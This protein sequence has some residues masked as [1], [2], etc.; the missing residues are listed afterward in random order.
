VSAASSQLA[1]SAQQISSGAQ[2]QAASLEETAASL[3]EI[4][5]TVK[6]NAD[7]A[8]H[9]SNLAGG[10]RD[11]AERG[12]KVVDSAVHAM[13]E[14]T[15][16]SRK[17]ADIITTIDE[18]AFQTN[19]LALNAAVE[20]ARAGEQGRGFGVVAAEVR[21]LAQRT[22]TAAKEIRGLIADSGSKVEAGT[23]QVDHSGQTLAA[24]V[25]SVKQ[26]TDMITVIADASRE[27]MAGIEQVNN[28]VTQVDQVT[29][30]N[31]AQT[32]E[33]SATASSLSEKAE[34][35]RRRVSKFKLGGETSQPRGA[36]NVVALTTRKVA[37]QTSRPTY[38]PAPRRA[39]G[40]YD[41]F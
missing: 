23:Q 22:G 18:I 25:D 11:S 13:S 29:Q 5:T 41:E 2:E 20:A 26:V 1:A 35:L 28:A 19:L 38:Q 40:G 7:S 8:Q 6:Q 17:I 12:G 37:R 21:T 9:A 36:T 3:E 24:I 34:D 14:I 39:A 30:L 32:E 33:L 16:S 31:A 15:T 27:Q 4:S 10:A